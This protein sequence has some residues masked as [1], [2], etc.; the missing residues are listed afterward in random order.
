MTR[1]K[2]EGNLKTESNYKE[3]EKED[4]L[5]IRIDLRTLD[6]E[7]EEEKRKETEA[8]EKEEKEKMLKALKIKE[9]NK[10]ESNI[11]SNTDIKRMK[12]EHISKEEF[13]AIKK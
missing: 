1:P 13:E 6:K 3:T 2:T 10:F 12:L 8:K 7:E 4:F 9:N 11:N 5:Q